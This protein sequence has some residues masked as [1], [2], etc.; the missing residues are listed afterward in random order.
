M[1]YAYRC[2]NEKCK[3]K[4]VEVI[5]NRPMSD[6]AKKVYCPECAE[7]LARTYG[8]ASISTSDGFKK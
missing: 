7:V 1:R 3:L 5:V 2:V 8:G 6:S 4:E